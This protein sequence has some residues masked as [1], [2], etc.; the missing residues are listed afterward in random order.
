MEITLPARRAAA[1]PARAARRATQ[2]P[3]ALGIRGGAAKTLHPPGRRRPRCAFDTKSSRTRSS[4]VWLSHL[5]PTEPA[6]APRHRRSSAHRLPP[7]RPGAA[8]RGL[9]SDGVNIDLEL[10]T[11]PPT[12]R[13]FPGRNQT[14][15][16][17]DHIRCQLRADV[18]PESQPHGGGSSSCQQPGRSERPP[19]KVP[20]KIIKP[21][22]PDLLPGQCP[23]TNRS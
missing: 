18:S 3:A 10:R 7:C 21:A 15:S 6:P 1:D 12:P 8:C 23:R 11:R 2:H 13:P 14:Q 4:F 5:P 19:H 16:R 22:L 9:L 20:K 17:R